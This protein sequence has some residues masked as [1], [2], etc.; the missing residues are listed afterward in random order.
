[1]AYKFEITIEPEN[2][3]NCG[4]CSFAISQDDGGTDCAIFQKEL[5][6]FGGWDLMHSPRRLK[7]C[8]QAEKEAVQ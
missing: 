2:E 7:E 1:M 5:K 3:T 4:N 8:N 6:Q